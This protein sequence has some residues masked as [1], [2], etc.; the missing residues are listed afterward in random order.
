[1]IVTALIALETFLLYR[2]SHRQRV[3]ILGLSMGFFT[4]TSLVGVLG[5]NHLLGSL[6]TNWFKYIGQT[7]C[8]LF[9]FLGNVD[10]SSEYL[11]KVMD[12]QKIVLGVLFFFMLATPLLPAFPNGTVQ[13]VVSGLRNIMSLLLFFQYGALFFRKPTNFTMLMG[14]TFLLLAIGYTLI[15]PKFVLPNQDILSNEGDIV[16][17]FGLAVLFIAY[18][19]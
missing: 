16:R 4:L 17:I 11:R 18:L 9:I 5:D 8:L 1:M 14:F 10:G 15:I 7:T 12:W 13:A 19:M 3:F 6:N 2:K